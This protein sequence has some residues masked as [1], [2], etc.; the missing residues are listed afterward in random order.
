MIELVKNTKID[1]MGLK[2]FAF[3]FSACLVILGIVGTVQIY[4]G[5]ANLGIDLAGG[6]SI[7]LKFQ[8]PFSMDEIRSLLAKAGHG[9]ATLQEV[10]GENIL[11][12][13]LRA[14]GKQDEKMV[15]EP[16]VN[17]LRQSLAGNPF[18]VESVS[19][20]GPAIGHKLRQ[21]AELAML[22][23]AL[24]I[25]LYLAWRFE[26]KFGVAAAIATFHDIFA[27]VGIFWIFGIE[28][29]LLFITALLTVGGYSLTDTVV[30][31]DRIRENIRLRKKGTFSETINLS[32]NEVL[33]RTIVTSLTVFIATISLLIFGGIVL[34]N[35]ALALA[36]GIVIGTY[37]SIFVASPI[38]AL[39]RGEKM[40]EVKR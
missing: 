8:K 27:L 9:E 35:F 21:D 30:V 3:S 34:Y 33:S 22:I 12:V 6:T 24:A 37:S 40:I 11:L 25:I 13:K 23:S 26:F 10:S 38:I 18:V 20:I 36:I 39:W 29:D 19:E 16:M 31:F 7:Q 2:K 28:K 5:K 32:V 4:R 17:L 15:A 1:F 14:L